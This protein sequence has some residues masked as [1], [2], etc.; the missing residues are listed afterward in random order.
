M[1]PFGQIFQIQNRSKHLFILL[2]TAWHWIPASS[3]Y[4]LERTAKK[5]NVQYNW[6]LHLQRFTRF[7]DIPSPKRHDLVLGTLTFA[8]WHNLSNILLHLF[9]IASMTSQWRNK[10]QANQ[11]MWELQICGFVFSESVSS[12]ILW[13]QSSKR[14]CLLL[15][16]LEAATCS[17]I[18]WQLN[19]N[20]SPAW[21]IGETLQKFFHD[22]IL[23]SGCVGKATCQQWWSKLNKSHKLAGWFEYDKICQSFWALYNLYIYTYIQWPCM[24]YLF[25]LG[26]YI[27]SIGLDR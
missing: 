22:P 27:Q 4:T 10:F 25:T 14:F 2:M 8:I 1:Q 3:V 7:L 6:L 5:K 21:H 12:S 13:L 26:W 16:N 23:S 19:T 15:L 17:L 24:V 11:K 18:G 9:T 20:C